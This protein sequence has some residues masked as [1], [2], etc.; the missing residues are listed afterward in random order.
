MQPSADMHGSFT[1]PFGMSQPSQPGMF[2]EVNMNGFYNV[3]SSR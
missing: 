2:H 1:I 3:A